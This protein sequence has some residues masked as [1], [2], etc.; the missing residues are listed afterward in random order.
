MPSSATSS[1]SGP[2]SEVG[3]YTRTF[4]G[5][6]GRTKAAKDEVSRSKMREG[7]LY[8]QAAATDKMVEA[9]MLKA[10]GLADQNLL[11]LMTTDDSALVNAEAREYVQLRRVRELLKLKLRMAAEE[12]AEAELQLE[13][14]KTRKRVVG[15]QG[16]GSEADLGAEDTEERL[17]EEGAADLL[18]QRQ[19]VGGFG[20]LGQN[21]GVFHHD[22]SSQIERAQNR[23]WDDVVHVDSHQPTT[24]ATHWNSQSQEMS[25]TVDI[26]D[27][28]H[29]DTNSS[30]DVG[31]SLHG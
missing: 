14:N 27:T 26:S 15:V 2:D 4:K 29:L 12:A 25:Q 20:S 28:S 9:Q 7:G 30:V 22:F 19:W 5:R 6:P 17:P 10:V 11:L 1:G 18:Q 23:E 21:H 13:G 16:S 8:A 24:W 3:D 31:L